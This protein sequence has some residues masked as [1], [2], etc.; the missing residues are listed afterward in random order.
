MNKKVSSFNKAKR[1]SVYGEDGNYL[2]SFISLRYCAKVMKVAPTT[3][4]RAI[5]LGTKIGNYFYKYE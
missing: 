2:I 3:L 1:V 5:K 4:H